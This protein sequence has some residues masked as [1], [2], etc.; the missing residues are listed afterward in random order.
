M[1]DMKLNHISHIPSREEFH[2]E[3]AGEITV[4]DFC[5]EKTRRCRIPHYTH[6][7]HMA[8]KQKKP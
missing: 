1:T 7:E 6:N 4:E 8:K 3:Y 5:T 2:R